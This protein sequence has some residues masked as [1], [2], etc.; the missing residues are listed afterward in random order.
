MGFLKKFVLPIL[1]CAAL[2]L[3]VMS[4]HKYNPEFTW[5]S[6]L[7][8]DPAGYYVYLPA[9]FIYNFDTDKLPA[10]IDSL[11]GGG[12]KIDTVNNKLFTKYTCGVAILQSPFFFITHAIS[13]SS[14]SYYKGFSGLYQMVPSFA[15]VFYCFFGL[16]FLYKFL[17][18]YFTARLS[19]LTTACMFFGTNLYFFT[20]YGN[21]ASHV[22]SFALFSVFLY[23]TKRITFE[24]QEQK[25]IYLIL[26]S[27]VAALII[28][29]RPLN[30]IFLIPATFIDCYSLSSIRARL[31]FFLK[32]KPV[33]FLIAA[34]AIT[35]FPQL[36]YWKYLSGDWVYYSYQN[37]T[38]SNWKSPKL[39]MILFSPNNGLLPYNPIYFFIICALVIMSFKKIKN[40][41][42]ILL[43]CC[44]LIYL[45]ASW[46]AVAFGCGYGC[47]NFVEYTALFALPL[48]WLF[49]QMRSHRIVNYL[50]GILIVFCVLVNQKAIYSYDRCFFGTDWDYKEY[51]LELTRGY[52]CKKFI[53]KDGGVFNSEKEYSEAFMID[54]YYT[55]S[56]FRKARVTSTVKLFDYNTDALIVMEIRDRKDS[57]LVWKAVKIKEYVKNTDRL[58]PVTID[59]PLPM[60]YDLHAKFKVYIWNVNK[61]SFVLKDIEI[62]LK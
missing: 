24:N 20:V 7:W 10:H 3:L 45:S 2:F 48:G 55:L 13:N 61:Q 58:Q 18:F 56:N 5:R 60:E 17:E 41:L 44:L 14:G 57:T 37:E 53:L 8:A 59:F 49:N 35:F 19:V 29:I 32:P 51:F 16:L 47:R 38:F 52:Y 40:G 12:F 9:L 46:H 25:N 23:L 39:G 28:L 30:L 33:L 6:D 54:K 36:L 34:T 27:F 62:E 15:A 31:N 1:L 26:W 22:Y 43:A 50:T 42:S 4:R 11:C 21:G